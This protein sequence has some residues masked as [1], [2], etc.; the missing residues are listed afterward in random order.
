MGNLSVSNQ[1]NKAPVR[2]VSTKGMQRKDWLE[3]RKQGI[4]ASDAAAAVGIS[5]YQ[6]Q[7]ELWMIK[8]GR[9]S[10][11]PDPSLDEVRSPIYWGNVLEPI[12]AAH[13][14]RKTGRKVRRVNAVLQHPDQDKAWMLANL[15]YAVVAC[16]EVQLLE[17]KTAGEFGARLWKDGVPEYYQ[18]Q[19]QHQLAVT[20][21]Q[22]ADVAVLICGQEFRVYR[23][24]RDDALIQELIQL[25][26]QFWHWVETDTPPPA[27]GSD[28]ADRALRQL[29]PHDHGEVL[30]FTAHADL[31]QSFN[32]LVQVRDQLTSLNLQEAQLKQF[33]QQTLGDATK[34]R[35]ALGSISWK[36]SKDTVALNTKTLLKEQPDMLDR[37]GEIRQGSRRFTVQQNTQPKQGAHHD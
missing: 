4:G 29:Y 15:D 22:S 13:Y 16:D 6:S 32:Q 35:F 30:D 9:M 1:L 14:T 28:S 24:E 37:Y 27:D 5:P 20:G 18:C 26:R 7:L 11:L 36:R 12:V 3:V 19:V 2:L 31:N 17:C 8:T 34:A 21:K 23:I 25:E 10:G 33:L